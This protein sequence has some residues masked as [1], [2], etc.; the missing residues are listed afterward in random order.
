MLS[1]ANGLGADCRLFASQ[2]QFRGN[3]YTSGSVR[4]CKLPRMSITPDLPVT[5][6]SERFRE[7][8]EGHSFPV[9]YRS[10]AA[11]IVVALLC[12]LAWFLLKD[13]ATMPMRNELLLAAAL[14]TFLGVQVAFGKTRIDQTGL[15]RASLYKPHV[16]WAELNKVS[17]QTLFWCP[18]LSVGSLI[19]PVRFHAGTPELQAAF[20]GI[21]KYY[22]P[23]GE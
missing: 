1:G 16:T 2:H 19:G 15:H 4:A 13:A 10:A 20:K 22:G 9:F 17:Y 7:P 6:L 5:A 14:M 11:C 12:S 18:R 8:V 23:Q 3:P 21:M